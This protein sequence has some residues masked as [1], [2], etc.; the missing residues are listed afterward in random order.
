[1][2]RQDRVG[3]QAVLALGERSPRLDLDA[4]GRHQ[5]LV[6]DPLVERVGLDL[7]DRRHDLVVRDQVDQ[8]VG[9]EVGDADRPG[10]ASRR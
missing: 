1:M 9:V 7:V 6:G 5:L 2:R 4:L 10:Q 8:P 3:E